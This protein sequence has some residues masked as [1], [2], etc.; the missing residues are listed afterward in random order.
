MPF[1]RYG[2]FPAGM[3]PVGVDGMNEGNPEL[4]RTQVSGLPEVANFG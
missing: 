4:V 1:A 2:G 3:A